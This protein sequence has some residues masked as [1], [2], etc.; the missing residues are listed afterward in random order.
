MKKNFLVVCLILFSMSTKAISVEEHSAVFETYTLEA[1]GKYAK[2]IE[3][4]TKLLE[5]KSDDYFINYRLGWLFSLEK[6]Y[7]NSVDHYKKAGSSNPKSIEPWLALSLLHLN[8]LDYKNVMV[9]AEE[10]IKRDPENYYGNQRYILAALRTKDFSSALEKVDE[11]LKAYPTDAIFLEQRA[12]ALAE[13]G[14]F[15]LA[16]KA[17]ADLLLVSPSNAYG[18]YFMSKPRE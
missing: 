13:S 16:K 7:K 11:I 4:M 15:D 18:K 3:K 2:A 8:L 12:Y 1:Q 17:V 5:G 14:K 9:Y 6:K 10:V